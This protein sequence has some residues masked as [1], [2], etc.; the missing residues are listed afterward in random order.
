MAHDAFHTAAVPPRPHGAPRYLEISAA[1]F[2]LI[3]ATLYVTSLTGGGAFPRDIMNFVAGR[4]FLNV[5]MY[6]RAAFESDPARFYNV[7]VYNAALRALIGAYPGQTWSY[8]P[9]I[10]LIAWPFGLLNYLPALAL[11]TLGSV[12][13]FMWA[14]RRVIDDRAQLAILV[15]SPAAILCLVSGQFSFLAAGLMILI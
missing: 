15:I 11:F 10:M 12:A 5:W 9:A 14:A 4:D 8:P 3:V 6:G 2:F 13:F 1:I 7:D